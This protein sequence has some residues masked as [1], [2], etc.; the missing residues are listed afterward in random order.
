MALESHYCIG[1]TLLRQLYLFWLDAE[2]LAA[3]LSL[4]RQSSIVANG[5]FRNASSS[6]ADIPI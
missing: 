5:V 3:A 2:L 6:F 4:D 1:N